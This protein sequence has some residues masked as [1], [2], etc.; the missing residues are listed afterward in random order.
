LT[1]AE[2]LARKFIVVANAAQ[3]NGD[4]VKVVQE[5]MRHANIVIPA[6][7]AV[8]GCGPEAYRPKAAFYPALA[9]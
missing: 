1:T 3:A 2:L 4:D 9:R 8:A 6:R 7:F 5:L